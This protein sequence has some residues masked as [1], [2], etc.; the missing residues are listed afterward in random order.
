MLVINRQTFVSFQLSLLAG[1]LWFAFALGKL[2]DCV[3]FLSDTSEKLFQKI[4]SCRMK[5]ENYWHTMFS[6]EM[7]STLLHM[8]KMNLQKR[9][10][11]GRK[12]YNCPLVSVDG[13]T[14]RKLL[15]FARPGRPLV[16]NFGSCT[17]PE[18]IASLK[19]F[20]QLVQRFSDV[21]DFLFI[22]I[23]EAHPVDGWAFEVGGRLSLFGTGFL[24]STLH[25]TLVFLSTSDNM[26]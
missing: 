21:A 14:Y 11:Q 8:L 18:F 5:K 13:T 9:V 23:E 1:L 26:D 19:D 25:L 15:D 17:W 10:R 4:T 22:Y 3:P 20:G 7:H 6:S 16:L 12:A 2:V 24:N